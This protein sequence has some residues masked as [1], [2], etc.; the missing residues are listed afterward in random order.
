MK[1]NNNDLSMTRIN[2]N[3]NNSILLNKDI[4]YNSNKKNDEE[5]NSFLLN[6]IPIMTGDKN[7][8]INNI[9]KC[10]LPNSDGKSL[11]SNNK[12]I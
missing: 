4:N 5:G 7:A 11:I 9:N 1:I 6:Q 10:N 2:S 8:T 12:V 3:K